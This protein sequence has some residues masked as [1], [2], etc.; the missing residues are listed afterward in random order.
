MDIKTT[1]LLMI[2]GLVVVGLVALGGAVYFGKSY[3]ATNVKKHKYICVGC[4]VASFVC[5]V[6]AIQV[7]MMFRYVIF[8]A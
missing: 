1:V 8:G 5:L 6:T 4:V 7:L 3:K 2:I